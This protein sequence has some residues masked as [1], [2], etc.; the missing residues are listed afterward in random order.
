MKIIITES[1]RDNLAINI[2]EDDYPDLK[3]ITFPEHEE[4]FISNKGMFKMSY[5]SRTKSFFVLDE[6]WDLLKN[7]FGYDNDEVADLLLD[8]GNKKFGFR[9]KKCYRVE[10]I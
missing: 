10:R 6:I 1:K 9:A 3:K 4:I 5:I 7:M 2:I 8:W